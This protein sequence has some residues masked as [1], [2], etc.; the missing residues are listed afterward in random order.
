VAPLMHER[1]FFPADVLSVAYAFYVP[2]RFWVPILVSLC[3][4]LSYLPFLFGVEPVPVGLLA[5]AMLVPISVV[6]MDCVT[7]CLGP[8]ATGLT[9]VTTNGDTLMLDQYVSQP[10]QTQVVKKGSV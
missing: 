5:I 2:R 6:L 9:A 7:A 1:Y 3:S 10:V 4:T 8:R